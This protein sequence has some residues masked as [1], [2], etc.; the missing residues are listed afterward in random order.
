MTEMLDRPADHVDVQSKSA[1]GFDQQRD[2]VNSD[3]IIIDLGSSLAEDLADHWSR[4][5]Q[6]EGWLVCSR[7]NVKTVSTASRLQRLDSLENLPEK[8]I[9]SS[10]VVVLLQSRTVDFTEISRVAEQL[11]AAPFARV[12]FVTG[13]S[14]HFA[15]HAAAELEQHVD[16]EF[17]HSSVQYSIVRTHNVQGVQTAL[18]SW[19]K[20]LSWIAPLLNDSLRSTFPTLLEFTEC[21]SG[22]FSRE[23]VTQRRAVTLLGR[24]ES[25]RHVLSKAK[26]HGLATTVLTSISLLGSYLGLGIGLRILFRSILQFGRPSWQAV[27]FQSITPKSENELLSLCQQYNQSHIQVCGYN[28][29]VNH[30][31]WK[32]P[33]QTVIP[34]TQSG[35]ILEVDGDHLQVDA[36]VT[37]KTAIAALSVVG[38]QFYVVPN[39]SYIAMGTAFFVPVHGSGSQVSTLGD[40]I[41]WVRLFDPKTGQCAEARRGEP[42]FDETM[43]NPGRGLVLL[44]LIFTV[45]ESTDFYVQQSEL[46]NPTAQDVWNVFQDPETS[47]IEVRKNRAV[48]DEVQIA[49]YYT[50]AAGGETRLTVPR[51]SIGRLW[52]RLEENRFTAFLFHWMVRTLAFHVELFLRREEFLV[53]WEHHRQLPVSKIQL[54][55]V[56]H[57]GMPHSPFGDEDCVSADLFM[58]KS[59]R[60]EF[61][62]FLKNHLPHV[63]SNPGKQT[64]TD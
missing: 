11:R 29:G 20:R 7:F 18:S 2:H 10:R 59:R 21:L 40:T 44:Q 22:E 25:W 24:N 53:F 12:V 19:V 33:N 43:Y 27:N 38:K 17:D 16:K 47:N 39:F 58:M 48:S 30:F 9:S 41:Q 8:A 60:N 50:S 23:D 6:A 51:D 13:C 36:G 1:A 32:F 15:D 63:R 31:G 3:F 34:T 4:E 46:T 62:A 56:R 42:L 26:A 64:A 49:K 52:D 37:L 5:R 61:Q 14:I 35:S 28:N 54:R 55:F 57:D 45:C